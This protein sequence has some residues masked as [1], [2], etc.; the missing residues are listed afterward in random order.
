MWRTVFLTQAASLSRFFC[1]SL[2]FLA[3]AAR[4]GVI[5]PPFSVSRNM[6]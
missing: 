3:F 2:I 5:C 1:I 6:A 4:A